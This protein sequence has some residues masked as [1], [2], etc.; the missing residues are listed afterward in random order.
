MEN[1]KFEEQIKSAVYATVG[2]ATLILDKAKEIVA[3]CEQVGEK[4]CE[5]HRVEN[6]ELMRKIKENI[7]KS[8]NM[9]IIEKTDDT[10]TF[11]EKMESLSDEDLAKIKAKLSELE[12]QKA[13]NSEAKETPSEEETK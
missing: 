12:T 3:K 2:A 7:E 13:S 5:E 8:I 9:T 6:E 4:T 1:K 10:D 11:V